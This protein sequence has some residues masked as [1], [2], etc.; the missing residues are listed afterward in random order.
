MASLVISNTPQVL[1]ENGLQNVVFIGTP[2]TQANI[3]DLLTDCLMSRRLNPIDYSVEGVED[4][5]PVQRAV[6]NG[7]QMELYAEVG[8][9]I[10]N[11]PVNQSL[12]ECIAQFSKLSHV[13][14]QRL[15]KT[16]EQ[17]AKLS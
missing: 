8:R 5:L 2:T 1:D 9:R 3:N 6:G 10:R 13:E 16:S 15:A 17:V 7:C 4:F 14:S 11:Y 12:N